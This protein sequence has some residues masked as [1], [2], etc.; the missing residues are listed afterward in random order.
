MIQKIRIL[1][2]E[3]NADDAMMLQDLLSK[4][5]RACFDVHR[6][7]R[8]ADAL[9]SLESGHF[10]V[11]LLDLSLPDSQ[12]LDTFRSVR[13]RFSFMPIILL[14]GLEDEAVASQAVATGA[15]DY[16]VKAQLPGGLLV[17]AILYALERNQANESIKRLNAELENRIIQLAA[18][19]KD[20][21]EASRVAALTRDQALQASSFKSQFVAKMSHEIRNPIAALINI[22]ELL[23]ERGSAVDQ[24]EL[25]RMADES[26]HCLLDI[27]NDVL[28]LSK[29]EA[30]KIELSITEFSPIPLVEEVADLF[31]PAA[32]KKQLHIATFVDPVL[33][34]VLEGDPIRLRQ[35]LLNFVSNA[36][37][38]TEQGEILVSATQD[39]EDPE[40]VTVRFSVRD[41]GSGIPESMISKL[42]QPFVQ[43]GSEQTRGTGLGLSICKRLVDL[44]QGQTGVQSVPG[45]GSTFWMSVRLK[46]T[47]A[48]GIRP[49][50][51]DHA[52]RVL[53][54]IKVLTIASNSTM[55]DIL[56][57]Y[58]SAAGMKSAVAASA[59]EG[60]EV[61]RRAGHID[62]PYRLV[63]IDLESTAA[64]AFA[65][66]INGDPSISATTLIY[67]AGSGDDG[68]KTWK[69]GFNG[70]VHKPVHQAEL[71]DAIISLITRRHAP[72]LEAQ[73]AE[74]SR[75]R[76]I[77]GSESIA[78]LLAEDSEVI[79]KLIGMQLSKLGI[80]FKAV[81]NG[82]EAVREFGE[83]KYSLVLMDI[84][85]PEMDGIEATREIRKL[86]FVQNRRTP[87]IALTARTMSGDKDNC[88]E[89]GM[90]DYLAKPVTMDQLR[91]I[92]Q[93]WVLAD[94]ECSS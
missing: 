11:I 12:G 19:N 32:A 20:L 21:E 58:V 62:D 26:A 10:D 55:R 40:S 5:A 68:D 51:F 16:L 14:T 47:R 25:L 7:C 87:I 74:S 41:S 2:V 64:K 3:D 76:Q 17:R 28:D 81:A 59:E 6:V 48:A 42:F 56:H 37:N 50:Y 65:C 53:R 61:L 57:R 90:D 71:M 34:A 83:R 43:L 79:Q 45:K 80:N 73:A 60:L 89:A 91:W 82:R 38:H 31:V 49:F 46:R 72:A 15:Q 8:L 88:L 63:I 75:R 94:I 9:D 78:V 4:S 86:E 93:R 70:Y 18:A 36:I 13:S 92:I 27:I 44:M 29:I 35:V 39:S 23:K 77:S 66:E 84:G 30:G 85:M 22:L 24:K 69:A 67:V 54:P 1:L 52:H 33:P